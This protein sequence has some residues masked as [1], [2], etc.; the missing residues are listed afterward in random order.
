HAFG[1]Q[2]LY[3]AVEHDGARLG[4]LMLAQYPK[5][6]RQLI[7]SYPR[8]APIIRHL[9]TTLE[10]FDG[11]VFHNADKAL[12]ILDALLSW[13]DIYIKHHKSIILLN[14]LHLAH[15]SQ[16]L[17]SEQLHAVFENKGYQKNEWATL[18]VN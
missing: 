15:T 18:L 5:F 1:A 11:P 3:L 10:W 7:A 13:L 16:L 2:P 14:C 8:L 12:E 17:S 6:N 9:G 4:S